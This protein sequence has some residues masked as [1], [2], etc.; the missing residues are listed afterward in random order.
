M[1][2][3]E[4]IQELRLTLS[5]KEI[6]SH[7]G[8]TDKAIYQIQDGTINPKASTAG[9]LERLLKREKAVQRTRERYDEKAQKELNQ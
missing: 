9:A 1:N 2:W 8:V 6:A 3:Q 5:V 7:V 4:I